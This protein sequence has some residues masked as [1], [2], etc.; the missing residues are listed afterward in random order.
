MVIKCLI[1]SVMY[2]YKETIDI[3]MIVFKGL[4]MDSATVFLRVF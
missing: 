4:G 1:A 3:R 2:T